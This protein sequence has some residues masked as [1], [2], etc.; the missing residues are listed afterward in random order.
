MQF[1]ALVL[2]SFRESLDRKIFWILLVISAVITLAMAS[3]GFDGDRLTFLFGAVRTDVQG[4]NPVSELGRSRIV[5]AVI[6]LILTQ[7]LG[8]VGLILMI[9]ATAGS[10]PA[11]LEV[12]AID[13]L[14]VKPISRVRLFLYKY[15]ASMVFVCAQ[16]A[17]FVG[18]TFL[19][20]G[21]R[22]RVWAPGYLLCVPLIVLL[23]SYVYCV[24]ALVG[25]KTRSGVAAALVSLG[26]WVAFGMVTQ[27]PAVA[28][29]LGLDPKSSLSRSLHVAS[30]IP[31]KTGDIPLIAAR[32]AGAGTSLE[33]LPDAV[34]EAQTTQERENLERGR[35]YEEQRMRRNPWV[36]IGSSLVFEFIVV[37]WAAL[38]FARK[39]F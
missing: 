25:V 16:S 21:F 23:F 15:A 35:S 33:A 5:G 20:M 22:W 28:D 18:A 8:G 7:V 29:M 39:D 11:M 9:I 37:A 27:A 34:L 32:W 3:I 13:L 36:S 10:M 17:V 2:D 31:P 6:Y 14:L 12:G 24:S 30:W 4:Y 26:A 38:V 19:V 1:F